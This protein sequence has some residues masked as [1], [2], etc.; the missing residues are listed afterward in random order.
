[1]FNFLINRPNNIT[2]TEKTDEELRKIEHI[3]KANE[4]PN[5]LVYKIIKR[6]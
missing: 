5:D 6:K 2:M 4:Y 3:A 1:M